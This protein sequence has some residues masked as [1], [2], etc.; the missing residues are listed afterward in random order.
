MNLATGFHI[1]CLVV[2]ARF[3]PKALGMFPWFHLGKRGLRCRLTRPLSSALTVTVLLLAVVLRPIPF[4]EGV[5]AAAAAMVMVMVVMAMRQHCP[6][7]FLEPLSSR[8]CMWPMEHQQC[9]SHDNPPGAATR[10]MSLDAV[11]R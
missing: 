4:G 7:L 8:S 9:L 3:P 11:S 1:R 6:P 10:K 2:K 5:V